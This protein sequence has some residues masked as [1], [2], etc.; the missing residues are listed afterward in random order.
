[1]KMRTGDNPARWRGNLKHA[2]ADKH[3]IAPV[4]HHPALKF[5]DVPAFMAKVRA[6]DGL[7]ARALEFLVLTAARTGAV[8]GALESEFDLGNAVW[9]V[10]PER[11]GAK[12]PNKIRSRG[13]SRFAIAR[14]RFCAD[15]RGRRVMP[16]C[17][18]AALAA[19]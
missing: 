6:R 2:L 3:K 15:C 12:S 10:A 18:K 5:A 17:S 11:T 19:P 4:I 7:G 16:L 1:M 9:T 14:S 13:G 8:I